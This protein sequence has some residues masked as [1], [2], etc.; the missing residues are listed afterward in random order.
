MTRRMV[1]GDD[2]YHLKFWVKLAPLGRNDDFQS[3]SIFAPSAT[4][5]IPSEKSSINTNGKSTTHFPMSLRWTSFVAPQAPKGGSKT[6]N[7][8][9][10]CK[11]ALCL[12][13]VCYKVFLMWNGQYDVPRVS[14]SVCSRAFSF[15]GPQAWNQLPT[16]I[17]QMDWVPTF[18]HHLKT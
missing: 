8:R 13:K 2:S 10:T 14:P 17:P 1:G 3:Q 7:D 18:K 6:Q 9:F 15:A 4:A 5:V 11:I 12:K 16:S